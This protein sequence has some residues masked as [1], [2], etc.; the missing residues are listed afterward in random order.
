MSLQAAVGVL[1][2]QLGKARLVREGV[3]GEHGVL[4]RGAG[5]AAR[6]R[7]A[8]GILVQW[9]RE[10]QVLLGRTQRAREG[11]TPEG[12]SQQGS[13]GAGWCRV[14]PT[15]LE[16]MAT[17]L[18]RSSTSCLKVGLCEG[19]ACQQSRIIMYLGGTGDEG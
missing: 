6:G 9:H 18:S 11:T 10:V 3:V 16:V 14:S 2:G 12:T 8:G 13:G 7:E 19:T 15:W 17:I 5:G 4:A 1:G